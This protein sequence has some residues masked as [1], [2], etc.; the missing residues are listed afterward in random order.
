MN[1]FDLI[2]VFLVFLVLTPQYNWC[3]ED[4]SSYE[5]SDSNPS[6]A[7]SHLW[8]RLDKKKSVNNAAPGD[9]SLTEEDEE[10]KRKKEEESAWRR[11]ARSLLEVKN[12]EEFAWSPKKRILLQVAEENV[13]GRRGAAEDQQEEGRRMA[14]VRKLELGIKWMR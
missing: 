13:R 12:G 2:S 14:K 1:Y 11:E 9:S 4:F 8:S 6:A 10:V 5:D 7:S 3:E